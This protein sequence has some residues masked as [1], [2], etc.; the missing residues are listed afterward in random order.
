MGIPATP[1]HGH[2]MALCVSHWTV[3]S[4]VNKALS[5]S[6]HVCWEGWVAI[7]CV[8][9]QWGGVGW[10]EGLLA[11]ADA[12][13]QR[14]ALK[15][16]VCRRRPVERHCFSLRAQPTVQAWPHVLRTELRSLPGHAP[17]KTLPAHVAAVHRAALPHRFPTLT[18]HPP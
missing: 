13:A 9:M 17:L 6:L 8:E 12:A 14:L 18:P 7:V 16:W 10:V 1:P 4:T 3:G 11:G 2:L 5:S 15:S